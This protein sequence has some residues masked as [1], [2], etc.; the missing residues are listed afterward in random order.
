LYTYRALTVPE[1][2]T[3]FT[4]LKTLIT[5]HW[6]RFAVDEMRDLYLLAI[7]YCIKKLNSGEAQF[8]REA[9]DLYTVGLEKEILL[10]DGQL[11]RYTYNNILSLRLMLSEFDT[12]RQFLEQYKMYLPRRSRRNVYLYNLTIYHFKKQEY[13]K[14]MELL[15]QVQFRDVL[16]NLDT[17]RMLLRSYFE[18]GA[19][20][21]LDSLLESFLI[22]IRRRGDLSYHKENFLNLI[23]FTKKL[24]LIGHEKKARIQLRKTVMGASAVADKQWLLE[25]IDNW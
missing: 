11:S 24:L 20:E 25:K 8:I 5:T 9:L 17:R 2:A 15:Q 22:F 14:V 18:M 4:Q 19:F 7:N 12:A 10:E 6:Q 21:P 3:Y 16:Y 1:N 23:K 13:Q